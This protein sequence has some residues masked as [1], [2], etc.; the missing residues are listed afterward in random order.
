MEVDNNTGAGAAASAAKKTTMPPP[1]PTHDPVA[2]DGVLRAAVG[3]QGDYARALAAAEAAELLIQ[4][5]GCR[6]VCVV[7]GH[8]LPPSHPSHNAL[9]TYTDGPLAADGGRGARCNPGRA[10][11]PAPHRTGPVS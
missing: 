9:H 10:A 8:V 7:T 11:A 4:V 1:L 3:G 5:R 2:L 6:M